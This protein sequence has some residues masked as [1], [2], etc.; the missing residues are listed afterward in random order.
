MGVQAHWSTP[1]CNIAW[2]HTVP[3]TLQHTSPQWLCQERPWSLKLTWK[4]SAQDA[5]P[6]LQLLTLAGPSALGLPHSVTPPHSEW[7]VGFW[8][9]QALQTSRYTSSKWR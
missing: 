4:S 5:D 9:G 8:L 7:P 6:S 1:G 2:D 3:R